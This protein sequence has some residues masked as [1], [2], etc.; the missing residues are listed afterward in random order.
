MPFGFLQLL[1]LKVETVATEGSTKRLYDSRHLACL[2]CARIPCTIRVQK[3]A[4]ARHDKTPNCGH[5]LL[6]LEFFLGG[7]IFKLFCQSG[8]V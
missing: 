4:S 2:V 7:Q 6:V 8:A 5:A 3:S 1:A